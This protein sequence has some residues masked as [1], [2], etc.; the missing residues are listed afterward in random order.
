MTRGFSCWVQDLIVLGGYA[1]L[2]IRHLVFIKSFPGL[3][4]DPASIDHPHQQARRS[5]FRVASFVVEDPLD[6]ETCVESDKIRQG[7]R[8]HRMAHA[9]TERRV[10]IFRRRNTLGGSAPVTCSV[11]SPPTYLLEDK[12]GFIEHRHQDC[13]R[14]ETWA[15][16]RLGDL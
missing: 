7:K 10:D 9:Q 1:N 8:T 11:H 3:L 12:D 2:L 4:A 14:Y 6:T 16:R 5:I 13:V 15:V